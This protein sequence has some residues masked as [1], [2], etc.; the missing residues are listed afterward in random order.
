[1]VLAIVKGS[2]LLD[3]TVLSK[4]DSPQGAQLTFVASRLHTSFQVSI[5]P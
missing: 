4:Y 5:L 1:M 2:Q 3:E